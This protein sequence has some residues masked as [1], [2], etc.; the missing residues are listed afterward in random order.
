MN[1]PE[2]KIGQKQ[3]KLAI[4]IKLIREYIEKHFNSY[5]EIHDPPYMVIDDIAARQIVKKAP[6]EI[7][8]LYMRK[9]RDA[10]VLCDFHK[11]QGCL[12]DCKTWRLSGDGSV[13]DEEFDVS[14]TMFKIKEITDDTL[15]QEEMCDI[16]WIY[17]M[18]AV[19]DKYNKEQ[20]KME[21]DIKNGI[22]PF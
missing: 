9:L 20:K 10:S 11:I 5:K 8:S 13:I 12:E 7:F 17:Y 6:D 14:T 2:S 18:N 21:E 22:F 19:V 15:R 4:K 1:L 3:P 16:Q